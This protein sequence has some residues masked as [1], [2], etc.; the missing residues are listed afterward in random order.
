MQEKMTFVITS[1][2]RVDLLNKTLESFFKFNTYKKITKFFLV[3]DST[4]KKVYQ[5]IKKKWSKDLEIICNE[6]KEGQIFSIEKIYK[7][8]ETPLIFHCE[9]DWEFTRTGFIE[10]SLKIMNQDKKI[11]QVWLESEQSASEH[12]IFTYGPLKNIP[13]SNLGYRRVHNIPGWEWGFFSFRPAVKRMKDYK[14]INGYKKFFNEIDIGLE[15]KKGDFIM[16]L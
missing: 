5:Q 14:L 4:D 2:G 10:D 1:C 13:R 3:E 15:Y 8:I 16:L 7:L 9:D 11:L 6:K 12:D